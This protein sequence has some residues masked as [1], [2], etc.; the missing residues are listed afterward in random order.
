M[1][2]S[3]EPATFPNAT[4]AAMLLPVRFPHEQYRLDR[5]YK[6]HLAKLPKIQKTIV[7]SFP[8]NLNPKKTQPS[9]CTQML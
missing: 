3:S 6:D 5:G 8:V 4:K 9:Q 1:L 2:T 7:T